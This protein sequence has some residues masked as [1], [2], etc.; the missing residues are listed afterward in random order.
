MEL[1]CFAIQTEP[2]RRACVSCPD[3]KSSPPTAQDLVEIRAVQRTFEGAYIRTAL[4][5]FAFA[6]V[7]LK[8]F[9]TEFYAHG[10]LFAASGAGILLVSWYRR[11]QGQRASRNASHIKLFRTS[12]SVVIV[13]TC[14]SL[15]SYTSLLALTISLG[16]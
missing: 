1:S 5:Q 4:G 2:P 12:G 6:L 7:V 3:D 14:V 8:L 13:L 11:G 10:A 9:A 16:R 15:A